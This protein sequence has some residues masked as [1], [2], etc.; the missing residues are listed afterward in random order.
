MIVAVVVLAGTVV[1]LAAVVGTLVTLHQRERD[2]W[3][4]ERRA[5]V[6]RAIARHS[7]E[8]LALDRAAN[9]P[10]T[11]NGERPAPQFIEGLS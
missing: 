10:P 6:D 9:T 1:A 5:L 11:D 7:G 8:V 2:D 4:A 3:T